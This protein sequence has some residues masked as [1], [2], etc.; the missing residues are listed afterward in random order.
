MKQPRS[1]LLLTVLALLTAPPLL[2]G[3]LRVVTTTTDLKSIAES[4]GGDRVQVT[5]IA[6]GNRDPHHLE[7]KPSHMLR[8]RRADLWVSVGLELEIGWE[9]LILEGSR[10]HG[11]QIGRR[12]HLDASQGVV[13]LE[14]PEGPIIVA[15]SDIHRL[16]NPHYWLDPLNG[17]IVARNIA[18]RLTELAPDDADYFAARLTAFYRQL[19]QA[20]FGSEVVAEVSGEKLWA[21]ML[22]G[23]LDTFLVGK[24]LALGGWAAK[25]K[26]FRG[27]KIVTYHRSWS[28]FAK[29][30]GI[31]V[32]AEL[33]PK[34]GIPPGPAHLR[35]VIKTVRAEKVGTL[36]VEPF[37][38]RRAADIVAER[39]DIQVLVLTISVDGQPGVV[40]YVALI[41]NIVDQ[42]S[43][44]LEK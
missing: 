32:A 36:L 12:G 2:G 30:F 10:N 18:A 39:T 44:E 33:E 4:I 22:R 43:A 28:Y 3:P 31:V 21:L 34:P 16:G 38:D 14:V 40:D 20:M 9:R 6:Q 15:L 29:R 23:E 41:D 8:A 1:A 25:M 13:P 7:A 17:R 11:I 37:Y 42:L 5:A 35:D 26:P 24:K 19:D 27:G